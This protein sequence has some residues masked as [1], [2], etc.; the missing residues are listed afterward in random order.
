MTELL[1]EEIKICDGCD[2]SFPLM[3]RLF[4]RHFNHCQIC[5]RDLCPEC[6]GHRHLFA[7]KYCSKCHPKDGEQ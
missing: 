5:E 3:Q 2:R 7:W 4:P 6:W 1:K